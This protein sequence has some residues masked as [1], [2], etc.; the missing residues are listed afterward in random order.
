M[1]AGLRVRAP[2][3]A[4]RIKC[5]VAAAALLS[6]SLSACGSSASGSASGGA[7]FSS[8]GIRWIVA[9]DPGGGYDRSARQLQPGMQDALGTKMNLEY[10]GGGGGAV[11]MEYLKRAKDCNT[12]VSSANPK[13]LL[14][15]YVQKADYDYKTDFA[16]VGGFTRD[17]SVL[18]AKSGSQWDS[19]KKV[20]DYARDN[21]GKINLGV[22]TLASDAEG[23]FS[24]EQ[25]AGVKFNIVPL[26]GG[27]DAINAL[28]GGKVQVAGS[29]LFNSVSLGDTVKVI[30]VM[31]DTNPIPDQSGDAPTV[32]DA[33]GVD[34]APAVNNYGLFVSKACKDKYPTQ[35]K[36]LVDALSSTLEK[37]D[38]KTAVQKLGETGWYVFTP[39]D[40]FDKEILDG[41]AGLQQFVKDANITGES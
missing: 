16:A 4:T 35:Y 33:L 32:K 23:P 31:N 11:A 21:P 9:S 14:G 3:S 10:Q 38:F 18:L 36:A 7:T 2:R 37:P 24:L 13:V 41:A 5:G 6:L 20:V 12:V 8:Q 27:S 19:L 34:M 28:L 40:Q 25:A 30:G 26:G 29:S 22:G 1:H 15:Q 39:P 17:Y